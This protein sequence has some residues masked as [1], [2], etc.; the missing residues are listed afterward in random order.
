MKTVTRQ[1]T[2]KQKYIP[3]KEHDRFD[4]ETLLAESRKYQLETH[5]FWKG[6][7]DH[8]V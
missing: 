5:L 3:K 8:R 7:N 2:G 6:G 1:K 4:F